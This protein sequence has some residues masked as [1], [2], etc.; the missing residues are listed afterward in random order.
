MKKSLIILFFLIALSI[1][2]IIAYQSSNY[3]MYDI[4]ADNYDEKLKTNEYSISNCGIDP[5]IPGGLSII[6]SISYAPTNNFNGNGIEISKEEKDEYTRVTIND[7]RNNILYFTWFNKNK[8]SYKC[9]IWSNPMVPSLLLKDICDKLM[10]Q[11]YVLKRS[12]LVEGNDILIKE[13]E[14]RFIIVDISNKYDTPELPRA[15]NIYSYNKTR[16]LFK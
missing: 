8:I 13:T 2:S 10:L 5:C 16:N 9:H 1:I 6:N 7:S 15:L 3:A 4:D 12:K 11:G 14:E